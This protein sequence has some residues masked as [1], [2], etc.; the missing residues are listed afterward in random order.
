MAD[1]PASFQD[2]SGHHVRSWEERGR[3]HREET[4]T[5][6]ERFSNRRNSWSRGRCTTRA[7]WSRDIL[8]YGPSSEGRR[9]FIRSANCSSRPTRSP[10][11]E[12]KERA[13]LIT[14][15]QYAGETG[16][17]GGVVVVEG[18]RNSKKLEEP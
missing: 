3:S 5:A 16:R 2:R 6:P 15:D 10:L 14:Q 11:F 9:S 13:R 12:K 4:L 7:F 18:R 1:F 8:D 17:G